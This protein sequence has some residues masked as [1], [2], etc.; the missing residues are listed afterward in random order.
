[1]TDPGSYGYYGKLGE[2]SAFTPHDNRHPVL[3]VSRTWDGGYD[4]IVLECGEFRAI[5]LDAEA[6]W[7]GHLVSLLHP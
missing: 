1:M 7:L 3:T 6:E 5:V 2:V 4:G